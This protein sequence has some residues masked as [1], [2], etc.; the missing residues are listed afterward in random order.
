MQHQPSCS[1]DAWSRYPASSCS[2]WS[3][4]CHQ[5]LPLGAARASRYSREP[6]LTRSAAPTSSCSLDGP[7][8]RSGD[9]TDAVASV[10]LQVPCG[11]PYSGCSGF[12]IRSPCHSVIFVLLYCVHFILRHG[13]LI[14]RLP[15][16]NHLCRI[17]QRLT[18]FLPGCASSTP[19]R[20]WRHL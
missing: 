9:V 11:N 19:A 13:F 20:W 1:R 14:N 15:M 5:L 8:N 18:N 12:Q 17:H 3:C 2:S 4:S 16:L 6:L 10:W 7:S